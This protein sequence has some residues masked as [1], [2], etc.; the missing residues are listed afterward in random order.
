MQQEARERQDQAYA[1]YWYFLAYLRKYVELAKGLSSL[2]DDDPG[3]T[4]LLSTLA[5]NMCPVL[6]ADVSFVAHRSLEEDLTDWLDVVPASIRPEQGPHLESELI[7][8]IEGM[9]WCFPCEGLGNEEAD[10]KSVMLFDRGLEERLPAFFQGVVTALALC[11]V[12]LLGREYFLFFCNIKENARTARRYADFDKPMLTVAIGLV[13]AGFQSGVR[14]GRR[15]EREIENQET[16]DYLSSLV[17]DLKSPI[18]TVLA[19]VGGLQSAA[20][21]DQTEMRAMVASTLSAAHQLDLL[22][23]A[24]QVSVL[25]GTLSSDPLQMMSIDMPLRLA[26]DALKHEA[27]AESIQVGGPTPEDDQPFP[28][29]PL[30]PNLL[31]T[32]FRILI[33]SAVIHALDRDG[34]YRPIQVNGCFSG[35]DTYTIDISVQL[36]ARESRQAE[37][38]PRNALVTSKQ[39]GAG[40]LQLGI[41]S[42]NRIAEMHGAEVSVLSLPERSG[43][44]PNT[45]RLVF[46]LA[47]SKE[48]LGEKEHDV[49]LC[50]AEADEHVAEELAKRLKKA[51]FKPW[52]AK[53]DLIPG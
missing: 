7:R 34:Q 15:L 46:P 38:S 53:W 51:R 27:K 8:R 16:R 41:T 24:I 44:P 30:Y 25:L 3:R 49:F 48:A 14:G 35:G 6:Q 18:Q 28:M 1:S 13:E 21:P 39:A 9:G 12:K 52:F 5:A 17:R 4:R 47:G 23:D 26:V 22:A 19:G 50:Y 33:R 2:P 42:I 31:K 20:L 10:S 32:A 37:P 29:I 11:R 43:S 40:A 45:I 36:A